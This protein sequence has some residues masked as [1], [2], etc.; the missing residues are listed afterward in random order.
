MTNLE[1]VQRYIPGAFGKL[2]ARAGGDLCRYGEAFAAAT[3]DAADEYARGR[4]EAYRRMHQEMQRMRSYGAAQWASAQ[5]AALESEAAAQR[6]GENI[7]WDSSG[8]VDNTRA[9]VA[10]EKNLA[11]VRKGAYKLAKAQRGGED[12]R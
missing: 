8:V 10:A 9:M 12:G 3:K 6:G 1:R 4:R 5:L 7:P 2:I 11:S